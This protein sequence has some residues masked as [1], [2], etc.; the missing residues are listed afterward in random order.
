M[1]DNTSMLATQETSLKKSLY[2]TNLK[3][4]TKGTPNDSQN[5]GTKLN[6]EEGSEDKKPPAKD[7]L[8]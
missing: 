8:F 6:K 2:I 4:Q 5:Y 7:R 3:K 1:E